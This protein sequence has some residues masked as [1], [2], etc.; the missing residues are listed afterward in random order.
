MGEPPPL[1][2]EGGTWEGGALCEALQVPL[3]LPDAVAVPVARGALVPG[4]VAVAAALPVASLRPL[5]VG[6]PA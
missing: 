2:K 5:A 4:A 3:T 1:L 6:A